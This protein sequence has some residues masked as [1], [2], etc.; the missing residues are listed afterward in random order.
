M[1]NVQ[2]RCLN[3]KNAANKKWS[4]SY[5]IVIRTCCDRHRPCQPVLKS[6]V[7]IIQPVF[8][9]R[10]GQTVP[11]LYDI[12]DVDGSYGSVWRR[13]ADGRAV[14]QTVPGIILAQVARYL[15]REVGRM[16]NLRWNTQEPAINS[17]A[18]IIIHAINF[19]SNIHAEKNKYDILYAEQTY[20]LLTDSKGTCYIHF[21]CC[22]NNII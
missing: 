9:S 5:K 10:P 16:C 12:T 4:S 15:D 20:L 6:A 8:V 2:R 21:F 17:H 1:H 3:L 11:E 18:R 22:N 14:I 7:A 13:R 19:V